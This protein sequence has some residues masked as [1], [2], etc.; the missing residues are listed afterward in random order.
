MPDNHPCTTF[1]ILGH[2]CQPVKVRHVHKTDE[3]AE[4]ARHHD[5]HAQARAKRPLNAPIPKKLKR[6]GAPTRIYD[7]TRLMLSVHGGC[8]N[9]FLATAAVSPVSIS[10]HWRRVLVSAVIRTVAES[11]VPSCFDS[12]RHCQ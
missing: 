9:G 7:A 1:V 11:C 6:T 3:L 10:L 5:I 12:K 8:T 4:T 2:S